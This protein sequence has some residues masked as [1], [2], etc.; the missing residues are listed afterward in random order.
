MELAGISWEDMA[1][2][3][4]VG[5]LAQMVDSAIG[6]AFGL[7]S[8]SLLA[9]VGMPPPAAAATVRTVESFA[10]GASG[11]AHVFQRNVDWHVFARLVVP[12]IIGSLC[13]AWLF[14]LLN[15]AVLRPVLFVYVAAIGAY[16]MWWAPRRAHTFRRIRLV[17]PLGF[18]GGVFDASGGGGWGP[19]VTGNLL[20]QGMTPKM[21][22]GTANAAEFFV[23]VTILAVFTGALGTKTFTTPAAGL[24]IGSVVAAPLG[25]WLTKR[26][27]P[28]AL[29]RMVG[30]LLIVTS[31][32]ALASLVFA[33]TPIFR[34]F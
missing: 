23:T 16:L 8:T 34:R 20:A 15:P 5:F 2:F 6:V 19:L 10:S 21:A 7:A 1:P 27:A 18:V 4:A 31:V 30:A 26:I 32:W 13:T 24:L 25:A 9:L 11:I 28:A 29:L 12:G 33:P 22:V 3:I 14:L 17:G